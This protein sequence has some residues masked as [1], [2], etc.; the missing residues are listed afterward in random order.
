MDKDLRDLQNLLFDEKV[1]D[2][3]VS[4]Y[5]ASFLE[6]YRDFN[7]VID[8][9]DA[10]E[11]A[12]HN[13]SLRETKLPDLSAFDSS[14][15][16]EKY[17]EDL[18]NDE[19]FAIPTDDLNSV[20]SGLH[21]SN[22]RLFVVGSASEVYKYLIHGI[23]DS[24]TK[25]TYVFGSDATEEY[26]TAFSELE[27]SAP[28]NVAETFN[29]EIDINC[30]SFNFVNLVELCGCES[31]IDI[32][33]LKDNYAEVQKQFINLILNYK[34]RDN[35]APHIHIYIENE[36]LFDE[37]KEHKMC[38]SYN[39]KL[40]ASLLKTSIY[41]GIRNLKGFDG[42]VDVTYLGNGKNNVALA[43][44]LDSD[45]NYS[46]HLYYLG[47]KTK[48]LEL[49]STFK[50]TLVDPF[51][52]DGEKITGYDAQGLIFVDTGD[53]EKDLLCIKSIRSKNKE[54]PIYWLHNDLDKM[55]V[56]KSF[57]DDERLY[58]LNTVLLNIADYD[59][60]NLGHSY[61][62]QNHDE[63]DLYKLLS[64]FDD[65]GYTA[66]KITKAEPP[67]DKAILETAKS[68]AEK[69]DFSSLKELYKSVDENKNCHL[70]DF[71]TRA[72]GI[73][74]TIFARLKILH[75]LG[76]FA[77][78]EEFEMEQLKIAVVRYAKII[79]FAGGYEWVCSSFENLLNYLI[80]YFVKCSKTDK[81]LVY[82]YHLLVA[83]YKVYKLHIY[84]EIACKMHMISLLFD[85][86]INKELFVE[87]MAYPCFDVV[88]FN[89]VENQTEYAEVYVEL[90]KKLAENINK[91][92]CSEKFKNLVENVTKLLNGNSTV[93]EA[94]NNLQCVKFEER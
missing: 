67:F 79:S 28:I 10:L 64:N 89:D 91:I 41:S 78:E 2:S 49:C 87:R 11:T 54:V 47:S 25:S 81:E 65:Y 70:E 45:K 8:K 93:F 63:E 55:I 52:F 69:R 53:F 6:A 56:F 71:R 59:M 29:K 60:L 7:I 19:N 88:T 20:Y 43:K 27:D 50:N 68:L 75:Y 86:E 40:F 15:K 82:I 24:R 23:K 9:K 26:E 13:L 1:K 33:L 46:Q 36:E 14:F 17:Y 37:F 90:Y 34:Y 51:N 12:I 61:D 73:C 4:L 92:D 58:L 3:E 85:E 32:V 74:E 21:E 84:S 39:E 44:L 30:L 38:V 77:T 62:E 18:F 31:R 5:Y 66:Y 83:L 80:P 16:Y 76:K 94:F 22:N 42:V 72:K 48:D 35:K 57:F